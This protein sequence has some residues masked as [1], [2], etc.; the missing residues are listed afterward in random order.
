MNATAKRRLQMSATYLALIVLVI[1]TIVPLLWMVSTSLKDET[2]VLA[3]P[4]RFIPDPVRFGNYVEAFTSAPF[5]LYFWNSTKIT[6]SV[7]VGVVFISSL[8]GYAFARFQFPLQGLFF[9]ILLSGMMIPQAMMLV[10]L[11]NMFSAIGWVNRHSALIVP[12]I[13]ANTF[14]TFLFR[15]FFKSIPVELDESAIIDGCSPF[16]IYSRILMPLA[17]PAIATACVFAFMGNWNAFIRPLIFLHSDKRYTVTLGISSF[18]GQFSTDY[19]L[20]MAVATMALIPIIAVYLAA[21]KYFIR[22]FVTSGLK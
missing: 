21:Q 6:V 11:Y 20:T 13:L 16:A 4:P 19:H 7:M 18:Q 1:L 22:G 2:K 17:K 15:Q 8:G 14:T 3:M 12:A 10:P 5:H 9:V